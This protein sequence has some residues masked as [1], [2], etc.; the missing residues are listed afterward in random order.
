MLERID[1][2]KRFMAAHRPLSPEEVKQLHDYYR[3]GLTYTSNAL[4]GNTLTLV[5]TKIVIEDGLTVQGKSVRE[6]NEALGGSRAYD[7]MLKMAQANPLRIEEESIL[8]LH[9]FFYSGIDPNDA[10]KYRS[11][12]VVITGTEYIP[13]QPEGV[14]AL[15]KN[16]I[17]ELEEEKKRLHPVDL[18]AYAH[19]RLV[20]IH[21]FV[22]GNGRTARLLMNLILVNAGYCVVSIPPVL[23]GDYINSLIAAHRK[24]SPTDVPFRK[25]IF[26]CEIEEQKS[27][28]RLFGIKLPKPGN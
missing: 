17:D 27:V 4:E 16:F 20:Q 8:E 12:Q 10:G 11:V 18:A 15:M 6:C 24:E 23:R 19:R 2:N 7:L 25:L 1:S 13:P 9:R 22:D 14:P 5:E 21:P 3:L 26:Q 28:A